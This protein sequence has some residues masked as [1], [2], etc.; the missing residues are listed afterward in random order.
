MTVSMSLPSAYAIH[1][2][3]LVEIFPLRSRFFSITSVTILNN[4]AERG[5]P[6]FTPYSTWNSSVNL[7]FTFTLAFL[8]SKVNFINLINLT[9][10][11]YWNRHSMYFISLY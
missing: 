4:V 8:F 10:I 6:C 1:C 9:G 3:N 7:L 5:S 2:F 11:Q